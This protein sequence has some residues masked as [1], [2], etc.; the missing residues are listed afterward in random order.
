MSARSLP[1]GLK[2]MV[3]VARFRRAQFQKF[4]RHA[5]TIPGFDWQYFT[6]LMVDEGNITPAGFYESLNSDGS[7]GYWRG[8]RLGDFFF[9]GKNAPFDLD[10]ELPDEIIACVKSSLDRI[11]LHNGHDRFA[12]ARRLGITAAWRLENRAWLLG[13]CDQTPEE[14]DAARRDRARVRA[15]ERRR[16]RTVNERERRAKQRRD[17]LRPTRA[18]YLDNAALIREACALARISRDTYDRRS[19]GQRGALLAAARQARQAA[20]E[21]TLSDGAES[22]VATTY[23]ESI[24]MVATQLSA[25]ENE[26][27]EPDMGMSG[28]RSRAW[29][30]RSPDTSARDRSVSIRKLSRSSGAAAF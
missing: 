12:A 17:A 16:A 18:V 5:R 27:G 1:I 9:K 24:G 7:P 26:A 8:T 30:A 20:L 14:M 3:M 21:E 15:A 25:N 19:P 2:K 28:S 23:K 6:D 4:A 11:K 13:A 10:E 22:M 29:G